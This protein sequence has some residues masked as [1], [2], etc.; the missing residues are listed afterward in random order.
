MCRL[1]AYCGR[2]LSLKSFLLDPAQGLVKQAYAPRETMSATVNAD[3]FGIGWYD[4]EGEPAVYRSTL[5]A[6]A[7]P[8]LPHLGRSLERGL[9]LANVRSATDPRSSGYANTQPFHHEDLLF[10][11]NGFIEDFPVVRGEL[12][13]WLEP[14][15]ERLISGTTD[16]EYLF[17]ALCQLRR[18]EP[19]A[20]D[21]T[22]C[23]AALLTDLWGRLAHRPA[24]LNCVVSDGH[25]LI[26]LRHARN[27]DAPSLYVH[28]HHRGLN[29]GHLIASEPLDEERGWRSVPP[30]HFVVV[31][32]ERDVGIIP[33]SDF[34]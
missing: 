22:G 34:V 15:F 14:S 33:L 2:A 17:A 28:P 13:D 7:D 11:H 32:P 5:P 27:A 21:L 12:R 1:A 26:G 24:L 6:W 20:R 25:R 23:M 31:E 29:G 3:G 8:N 10:L 4:D 18:N 16:S 9:W 30:D 19:S